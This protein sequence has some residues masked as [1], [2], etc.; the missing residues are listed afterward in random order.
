MVLEKSCGAIVYTIEN[1]QIKY[2][3][4]EEIS[5]SHSF[6]KGHMENEETEEETALREI[7]EETDLDVE[8][9]TAFRV[10]EQYDPAEKTGVTKQVIYFLA[11]YSGQKPRVV[12]PNEVRALISLR[13]EDALKIMEHEKEFLKQADDYIKNRSVKQSDRD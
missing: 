4:V 13:L 11:K 7:R 2:L 12:R 3:I 8:L 6:P 1:E 9:F 10:S 5:G